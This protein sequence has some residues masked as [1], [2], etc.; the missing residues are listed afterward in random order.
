[1]VVEVALQPTPSIPRYSC[2]AILSQV[3]PAGSTKLI[4]HSAILQGTALVIHSPI[5]PPNGAFLIFPSFFPFFLFICMLPISHGS[6]LIILLRHS[7]KAIK[8]ITLLTK[9]KINNNRH[10][11]R[12]PASVNIKTT[13]LIAFQKETGVSTALSF[14]KIP[15]NNNA[16]GSHFNI[17]NR[18]MLNKSVLPGG[19]GPSKT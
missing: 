9:V 12:N 13:H 14:R 4:F 2:W 16:Y 18:D 17:L 7:N 10:Y 1:M 8:S 6:K 3:Q 15:Q 5:L 11:G 19:G